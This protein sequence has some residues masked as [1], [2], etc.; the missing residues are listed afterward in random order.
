MAVSV[1]YQ[2][3]T[4]GTYNWL[5]TT[6]STAVT[7]Q[8]D[9]LLDTWVAAVNGNA[10]N[11]NKQ[12][13]VTK[14]HASSTSANFVGWV[15]QAASNT[16]GSGFFTRFYTSTTTN[17]VVSFSETFTDNGT[18]GGY[19]AAAGANVSDST[20][21]FA[22]SGVVGE[23]V[24][25]SDTVNEQ[26]FF[27]LG[28]RT[29]NLTSQSDQLLI[30]KDT[31]GEWAAAFSDG[32]ILS[33]AFYMGTHSTPQRCFTAVNPTQANASLLERWNL[34]LS[35]ST[36]QLATAGSEMTVR[37]VAANANLLFTSTTGS[38]GFGKWTSLAGGKTAVC[39]GLGPLFV[40]YVP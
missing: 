9:N 20:I 15:I 39:L 33:G 30:Y 16:S 11:T 26:E 22:T 13:T 2:A 38:H 10:A 14:S 37:S 5:D 23:F 36:T 35:S 17:L 19:G 24:V 31:A 12:I 1:S 25:A 32:G 18:N 4:S 21:S 29:N 34:I 6:T 27:A 7:P 28:W 3:W 40:S 8:I